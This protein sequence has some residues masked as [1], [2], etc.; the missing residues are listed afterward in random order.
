MLIVSRIYGVS[1]M[2]PGFLILVAA[3]VVAMLGFFASNRAAPRDRGLFGLSRIG[4]VMLFFSAIG[5]VAGVWKEAVDL[6]E[7]N[8]AK[9]RS[10]SLVERLED[11]SHNLKLIR[12]RL[13]ELADQPNL[14]PKVAQDLKL[15]ADQVGSVASRYDFLSVDTRRDMITKALRED[16]VQTVVQILETLPDP[17]REEECSRAFESCLKRSRIDDAE[18]VVK[19]CQ[20]L[21]DEEATND[22]LRRLEYERLKEHGKE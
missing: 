13:D 8:L 15:L 17:A 16:D 22:R 9:K 12:A 3:Y 19:E 11:N 14:T 18:L 5:L 7:G 20:H 21:W 6:R 10:E 2:N 4:T 1:R